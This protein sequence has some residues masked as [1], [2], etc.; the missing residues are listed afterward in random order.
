MRDFN[1]VVNEHE[2]FEGNPVSLRRI[3]PYV[4][5]M[6]FCGMLNLGFSRLK[7]TWTN[8]RGLADLIQHRLDS[9]WAN[10]SWKSLFPEA[11]VNYLAQVNSDHCPFLLNLSPPPRS[12]SNRP[13]LFQPMWISHHDFPRV[14]NEA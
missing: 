9:F 13:F 1:E 5:C 4:D 11:N 14:V 8:K 2:K 7:Y 10:P 6:N 12:S 3:R